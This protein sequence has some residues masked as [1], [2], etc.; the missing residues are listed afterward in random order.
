MERY[1]VGITGAS[2]SIYGIRL[3]E[4]LLKKD[5]EVFLTI[6]KAGLLVIKEEIGLDLT[7]NTKEA[8]IEEAI[9]VYFKDDKKKITYYD[10]NHIDASIASGSFRAKAMVVLPCSM[11]TASSI[12]NG[13]SGNLL[14]RS[15]DVMLKE[16]KPL[17]VIPRETP[18]S[19]IHLENL[20]KIAKAGGKIVPAMPGF[21]FHPQTI[22]DMVYF[23]VGRILDQLGVENDL[24]KRWE[25]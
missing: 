3:I 13:A 5:C 2:G 18:F 4:E 1:I 20:L 16:G 9:R 10:I 24:F 17:L 6:T 21:Y 23:L 8:D 22:D 7:V 15:A 12:A 19:I 11:G 25:G 14:E